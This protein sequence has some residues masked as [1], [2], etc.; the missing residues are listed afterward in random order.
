MTLILSGTNGLSDIDGSA[1]T[2]AIRGADANT[3]I[4][5]PAADTIAFA[6]G[7]TE[8][9]RFDS[10]GNLGIGTSSPNAK[11]NLVAG[12][13]ASATN[14]VNISGG[15]SLGGGVFGSAGS[16]LFTNGYW[17]S[18]Y[19]A[20]SISG[21]DSGG[22]GGFLGFATTSNGGGTTGTPTERARIDNSGR[23]LLNT[24]TA[25]AAG[26]NVQ[27]GSTG[28]LDIGTSYKAFSNGNWAIAF[29]N[30]STSVVGQ[31]V[32]NSGSVAYNSSSDYRLK[33]NVQPITGALA[34]VAAL[35]PCIYTWKATGEIGEGFIAHEL[36]E[37]CPQAVTGE[38][39]AVDN[40][41]KPKYQGVDTSFLVATLTAAIQEQQA[42]IQ[43][44]TAKVAALEAKG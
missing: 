7:G 30:T 34:K 18:G 14:Q 1:A 20:A 2:P 6:E 44:L 37:V 29:N 8:V 10:S 24:T 27:I 35:K 22:S 42:M 13:A 26:H 31:I 41:G 16:I 5:F 21:M 38:K 3:G 17:A 40:E 12:D 33:D 32:I 23:L 25:F 11:L 9:A 4:F 15:R 39:D 28:D 36:A 19:G 43:E